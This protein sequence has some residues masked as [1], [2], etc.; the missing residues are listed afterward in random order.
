VFNNVEIVNDRARQIKGIDLIADGKKIDVKAQSSTKYINNPTKTYILELSFLGDDGAEIPGWF[1]N[2]QILTDVYAFL[3]IPKAEAIGG[4]I[5]EVSCIHEVELMLVDKHKLKAFINETYDDKALMEIGCW[6]R[7][8]G[9]RR[10][11]SSIDGIHFSHTPTLWEK[12][13]NIVGQKEFYKQFA[14][15]HCI[16]TP[17]EIIDIT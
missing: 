10:L 4:R 14:I 15:R 5:P 8:K 13:S 3:W 2:N 17:K 11:S 9:E 6:M 1:I 16:V 12:P 7:E